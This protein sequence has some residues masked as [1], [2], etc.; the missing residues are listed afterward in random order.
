MSIVSYPFSLIATSLFDPKRS[1][2]VKDVADH[3]FASLVAFLEN[4]TPSHTLT[5]PPMSKK[6]IIGSEKNSRCLQLPLDS[7]QSV[8]A[9]KEL[10]DFLFPYVTKDAD[11]CVLFASLFD[12]WQSELEHSVAAFYLAV[13]TNNFRAQ[14]AS[15]RQILNVFVDDV[16]KYKECVELGELVVKKFSHVLEPHD[17]YDI[18]IFIAR[19]AA[20]LEQE[21]ISKTVLYY[22]HAWKVAKE[23]IPETGMFA[24]SRLLCA[25]VSRMDDTQLNILVDFCD[26][27]GCLAWLDA[28]GVGKNDTEMPDLLYN[29][30]VLMLKQKIAGT[31]ADAIILINRA[32]V[33][34]NPE[35]LRWLEEN[36]KQ[37]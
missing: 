16:K 24:P 12:E 8:T 5:S 13:K 4:Y 10:K 3:Y 32:A 23:S 30:A 34:K 11:C 22:T 21:Y 9:C 28:D 36:N 7:E 37:V 25:L 29:V 2:V 15:L 6:F 19:S 31:K 33:A 20:N 17:K 18:L 26:P 14:T 27:L 1:F 35:A